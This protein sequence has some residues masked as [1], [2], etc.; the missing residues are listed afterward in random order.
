LKV[1]TLTILAWRCAGIYFAIQ[2]AWAFLGF[3]MAPLVGMGFPTEGSVLR[4]TWPLLLTALV[5]GCLATLVFRSARRLTALLAP[6]AAEEGVGLD[7]VALVAVGLAIVGALLFVEGGLVAVR[8]LASLMVS[9]HLLGE[10]ALFGP[11]G[12]RLAVPIGQAAVG[13]GVFVLAKPLAGWWGR[14]RA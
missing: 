6:R 4:F 10:G 14:I 1:S 2:A 11:S 13:V 5:Y 9:R 7:S 8:Q 3:A 12:P